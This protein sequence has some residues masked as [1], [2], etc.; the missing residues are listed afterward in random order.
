[1][2][3]RESI[4]SMLAGGLAGGLLISGCNPGEEG[5]AI[6]VEGS[7]LGDYGRTENEKSHDKEI[8]SQ[9]FLNEH[10]ITTIAV[11]CDLILPSTPTAGSATEA[12]VPEFIEFIVKDIK[13]H[14]LPIR[15]GIMWLDHR[16]A[17]QFNSNF[18]NLT[19]VQQKKLLDEIAYPDA[20]A[21]D[22]QQGVKFFSLM[23]NLVLTGYYTSEIGIKD[24]GYKGNNPN[25]W[26][27][28]P[29]EILKKHGL[30]YEPNWISKFVDQ[31]KRDVIAQWDEDGNLIS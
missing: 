25:V 27:G 18:K 3:R 7:E 17:R 30:E 9:E 12:G 22:V 29:E 10:E 16:S 24:L 14:Q 28:V 31:S 6:P 13:D 2:E 19:G 8:L 1:M 26:D 11:L 5:K 21:P 15:G 4:K 23:R 20:A